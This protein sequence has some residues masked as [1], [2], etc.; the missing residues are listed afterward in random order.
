MSAECQHDAGVSGAPKEPKRR[1]RE[2]AVRWEP[3]ARW[4]TE[5]RPLRDA[6]IR[7][8]YAAYQAGFMSKP[9]AV[10]KIAEKEGLST[11]QI[12]R[13]VRRDDES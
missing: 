9:L 12:W 11:R 6:F 2:P 13:I 5:G 10:S 1:R 4:N 3:P 8:T 7:F